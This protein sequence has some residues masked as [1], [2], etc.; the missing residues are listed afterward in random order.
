MT[1]MA[2]VGWAV[3][4]TFGFL[5][6]RTFTLALRPG[7]DYDLVAQV[8]CQA[9][10]YLFGLFLIL[11]VHAPNASIRDILGLRATSFAFY[12]LAIL[13]GVAVEL[14]ADALYD[15][16]LRRF[17][18]GGEDHFAEAYHDASSA[19]RIAFAILIA[20][21]GPAL[22]E[23]IFRGALFRLLARTNTA[24]MV[25]LVTAALFALAH[26]EMQL[27]LPIGIVGLLLAFL[28]K[29]SGSIVPS[30]L[31][32]G[33]FNAV[34]FALMARSTPGA[35]DAPAFSPMIVAASAAA[36]LLLVGLVHVVGSRSAVAAR[37]Q[38]MDRR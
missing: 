27:L 26:F 20:A 10:S 17:P 35:P 13:L 29:T 7:S 25:I 8:A 31:M 37:A 36:V 34:S 11:R 22:E 18:R 14:P 2:A 12:P 4:V 6:L 5:L 38:E 30:F 19:R 33:S 28:R 21:I 32:H 1:P 16:I 3:G 9:A 23:M 24:R 15:A